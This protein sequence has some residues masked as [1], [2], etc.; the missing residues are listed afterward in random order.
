[1]KEKDPN[2][3]TQR[4]RGGTR[5]DER[6]MLRNDAWTS[7][8]GSNSWAWL[9]FG[10]QS[11]V[12]VSEQRNRQKDQVGEVSCAGNAVRSSSKQLH[13]PARAVSCHNHSTT[14]LWCN[15]SGFVGGTGTGWDKGFFQLRVAGSAPQGKIHGYL[16]PEIILFLLLMLI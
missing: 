7:C 1:M 10:I 15:N 3:K 14:E 12:V 2:E 13:F 16:F 11:F 9:S 6:G 5:G 8:V 4:C